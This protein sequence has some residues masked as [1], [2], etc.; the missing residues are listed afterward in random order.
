VI[1]ASTL[2]EKGPPPFWVF[3]PNPSVTK[4]AADRFPKGVSSLNWLKVVVEEPM[5]SPCVL[6]SL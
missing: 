3:L 1:A 2:R 6:P 5:T 4:L